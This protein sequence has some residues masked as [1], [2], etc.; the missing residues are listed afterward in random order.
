MVR[1]IGADHVVDYTREDFTRSGTRYDLI[2]D[3]AGT[4]SL[5]ECR[6][7]LTARGS[8]VIVGAPSG[9]WLR[10]PDRFVKALLLSPFV[11][12]RMLP[13]VA[14][15]RQADL[16]VLKD[17]LESGTVKAVIDRIYGL[18]EVPEAIAYVEKGH[19]RGKVVITP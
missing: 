12:Q 2:L 18:S 4:H 17:L 11:S 9:P 6:R 8:Y 3:M 14:M 5:A 10:G 13:F 7:A 15:P 16:G 1:S 19:A